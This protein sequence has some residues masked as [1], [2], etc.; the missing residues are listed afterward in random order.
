MQRNCFQGNDKKTSSGKVTRTLKITIAV[1]SSS[2]IM[3]KK[4]PRSPGIHPWI[5]CFH[6]GIIGN[7]EYPVRRALII[8]FYLLISNIGLNSW[9]IEFGLNI[10]FKTFCQFKL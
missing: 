10:N 5:Q 7:H 9:W 8:N 4:L 2:E 1:S 3:S 6:S